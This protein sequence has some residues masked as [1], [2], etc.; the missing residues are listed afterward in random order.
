MGALALASM[1]SKSSSMTLM[2]L[3]RQM[4]GLTDRAA[5]GFA[6]MLQQNSSL[7]QLRFR[8]NRI[9]DKGAVALAS[10][11][12]ERLRRL[13]AEAPPGHEVHFE[14]DLEQNRVSEDGGLALVQAA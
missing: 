4:P 12:A 1:V 6:S 9:T 3:R 5:F 2:G 14:L 7:E 8:R 10:A 11:S 13:C